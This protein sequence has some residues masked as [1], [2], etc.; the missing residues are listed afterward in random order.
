MQ[1]R[2]PRREPL[3]L[4]MALENTYHVLWIRYTKPSTRFAKEGQIL[5]F[6]RV[7][8]DGVFYA[9]IWDVAVLPSWQRSGLGRALM[10]RILTKLTRDRIPVI[11]LYAEREVVGLYEKL[12]FKTDPSGMT[13]MAYSL[14]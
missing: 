9:S 13:G 8:S 11:T 6:A 10:E 1:V 7:I 2:F 14:G 5:G 4:R 3:R 12:G